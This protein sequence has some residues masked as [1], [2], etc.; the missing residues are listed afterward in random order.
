MSDEELTVGD[1]SRIRETFELVPYARLLG[2]EFVSAERGRATFSLDVR[3]ELTRMRG[4]VHGGAIVSLM[5]TAAAFAVHTLLDHEQWT[6]T[7]DLTIHFLRP[8]ITGRMLAHASV[9]RDG[10]RLAV[11]SIEAKDDAGNLI[12]VA[13]TTYVKQ[14]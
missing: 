8:A 9:V 10:R 4:I 3:P 14:T 5:D 12:A 11:I 2:M 7:V 6:V 13:T 1:L